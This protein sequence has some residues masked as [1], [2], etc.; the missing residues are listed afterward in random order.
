MKQRNGI[1]FKLFDY[2]RAY[3]SLNQEPILVNEFDISQESERLRLNSLIYASYDGDTLSNVPR[4]D[5]TGP[6][7]V[8]GED[9]LG[10]RCRLCRA[11]CLPVTEKP[12]ESIL[13]IKVPD[14]V[15]AFFNLTVWR[16]LN[17]NLTYS[18]FSLLE[19]LTNVFYHPT[20]K[21][22]ADKMRK[23]D[24]LGIP[25]G[26]NNFVNNYEAIIQALF[27]ANLFPGNARRRKKV[28]TFL[29]ENLHLTFTTV[30][31]FP[32]K[33]GFITDTSNG[34]M[35]AD[36]KMAPA[37][38]AIWTIV[39]IYQKPTKVKATKDFTDNYGERGEPSQLRKESRCVRSMCKLVE[40]YREFESET[41]YKK[42]GIARKL[43]Y[44]TRPHWT[45]RAVIISRQKPHNSTGID[46]PWS[47]SVLLFSV[48]LANKLLRQRY[49]PNE[50][51]ALLFENTLRYHP[52]LA[53]LFKELIAESVDQRIPTAFGRNPTLKRGSIGCN[54][55]ESIKEDP[56]DN[57]VSISPLNL[58][59]KNADFDG[60]ALWGEL[61]LDHK[62]ADAL[63]RLSLYTGIMDLNKPF[64][65]S[66][67]PTL[68]PPLV[69]TITNWIIEG[70]EI[71]I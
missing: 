2:E 66:R 42:P 46:L 13:W 32:S 16:I 35:S 58:N 59:D 50:L 37:I 70:D 51:K 10:I 54:G 30:L 53:S 5:C 19:Y 1:Y 67:N 65:V 38:D 4:C 49:T 17:K 55:I 29:Q 61:P 62:N 8:T 20:Q 28:L 12:L 57:T 69:A 52:H 39:G 27:K 7:A 15:P 68:P 45:Y 60:D 24:R 31:P 41:A 64:T 43:I 34:K 22:P 56:S 40:F 9:N 71:S 47:L 48:H 3:R 11:V 21:E 33:M 26:Y 25:R 63:D 44:G 14:G 6:E 23:L 18:G 36:H